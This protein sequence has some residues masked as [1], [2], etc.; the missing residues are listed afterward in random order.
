MSHS[1]DKKILYIKG[2]NNTEVQN[3]DVMLKDILTIECSD[4]NIETQI[5]VLKILKFPEKGQHR[6]VIS[7]LKIIKCIHEKYPNLQIENL[8]P[9]DLIV[10]YEKPKKKSKTLEYIKVGFVSVLVFLGAAFSIMSFNN[11]ISLTKMFGQLY[12]LV[13]GTASDG[14]SALEISYSIGLAIGILI[15]FNH[16]GKKRF[17]VDPTPMEVEMRLYENDIQTTLVEIYSR[18]GEEIDVDS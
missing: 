11:D 17:S 8:G 13:T 5:N 14:F 18:H 3:R 15:F 16:F 9:T 12:Y 2:E 6:V 10:T 7:V 4:S 1:Y